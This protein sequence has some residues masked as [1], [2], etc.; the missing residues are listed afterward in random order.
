MINTTNMEAMQ[1]QIANCL[2]ETVDKYYEFDEELIEGV[3]K[4]YNV[5]NVYTNNQ[6]QEETTEN[7]KRRTNFS[8]KTLHT[9]NKND[10][11][12]LCTD[13]GII[14]GNLKKNDLILPIVDYQR[15]IVNE[16]ERDS[17]ISS[18]TCNE[19]G[20]NSIDTSVTQSS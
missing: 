15:N 18:I 1:Q 6:K 4:M 7:T 5:Y 2:K 11:K 3:D 20:D 19:Q 9:M 8:I 16:E 12:F 17:D 14:T 13:F 10:V